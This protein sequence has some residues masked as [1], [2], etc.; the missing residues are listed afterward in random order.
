LRAPDVDLDFRELVT[1]A[2]KAMTGASARY[3][4]LTGK[5]RLA[6]WLGDGVAAC[7]HL[8][9][10]WLMTGASDGALASESAVLA[11]STALAPELLTDMCRHAASST[12]VPAAL[13]ELAWRSSAVDD[14]ALVVMAKRVAKTRRRGQDLQDDEIDFDPKLRSI[15]VLERVVLAVS[16]RVT[17]TPR[18][19]L[20]VVAMDSRRVRYVLTAL[21]GWSGRLSGVMFARVL[22]QRAGALSA[23]RSEARSRVASLRDWTERIMTDTEVAVALG[24][25]HL[26]AQALVD[27]VRTGR[28]KWV[29]GGS[30]AGGADA[31]AALEG[32][33]SIKPLLRYA[34]DQ[35]R[36]DAAALALWLLLEGHDR[37]R[38][39]GMVASTVDSLAQRQNTVSEVASDALATLERRQPGR[40]ETVFPQTPRGKATLA[41]ALA[42]AYRALGGLRD[43]R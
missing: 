22:R 29:D 33:A 16:R 27:R 18:A 8:D 28:H 38:G 19:A 3:G 24:V 13:L 41:S 5:A 39:A 12:A 23:A 20:P 1:D 35:R 32:A 11:R 40:L 14:E 7:Q 25:G 2:S 15:E 17:L 31:R 21:P 9:C 43:E 10:A 37:P 6:A 34:A 42:R 36:Q 26:T 4:N 30:I